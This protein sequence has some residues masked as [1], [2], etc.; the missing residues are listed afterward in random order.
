MLKSPAIDNLPRDFQYIFGALISLESQAINDAGKLSFAAEMAE[1]IVYNWM[2]NGELMGMIDEVLI[3]I[4]NLLD[5]AKFLHKELT[6][7]S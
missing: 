2:F 5:A 1:E 4:P 3:D 7:E 6:K